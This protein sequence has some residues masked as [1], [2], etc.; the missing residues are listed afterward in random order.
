MQVST[1]EFI[2]QELSNW[3]SQAPLDKLQQDSFLE[4][5]Q[6]TS[7]R[8]MPIEVPLNDPVSVTHKVSISSV[9]I[10]SSV[11]D[12]LLKGFSKLGLGN[13][14]I[15]TAEQF[16]SWSSLIEEQIE[17]Q[18][19][20]MYIDQLNLLNK[21]KDYCSS[22]NEELK[23][24]LQFLDKLEN[25]CVSVT[26]KTNVLHDDCQQLVTDRT[27]LIEMAQDIENKLEYFT[28]YD[29]IQKY[30]SSPNLIVTGENFLATLKKIDSCM[31]FLTENSSFT[32][33]Q[34][35][36]EKYKACLLQALGMV[37]NYTISCLE[38]TTKS[39]LNQKTEQEEKD[40]PTTLVQEDAFTLY[41]GKFRAH[42]P[43][44]KTLTSELETRVTKSTEYQRYLSDIHYSYFS[45]REL[46]LSPSVT[47][48]MN[49]L[50]NQHQ[51]DH[52]ALVRSSCAFML[53]VC[54]DEHQLFKHFFNQPT[55]QLHDMLLNLC[56]SLYDMLR[57][58]IIQIYHLETLAE[59]CTIMIEMMDDQIHNNSHLTSFN[60]V[61]RQMLQDV[62]ERLV[63]R[64]NVY[65]KSEILNYQPSPGDLKYPDKL[66]MMEQ[67]AN[68]L[69]LEE[70]NKRNLNLGGDKFTDVKLGSDDESDDK[71]SRRDSVFTNS[72]ETYTSP[73]DVFGMWF[74]TVKRVLQCLSKLYRCIDKT[75]FQGLSQEALHACVQSLKNASNLIIS[76]GKTDPNKESVKLVDGQLFLIKHLLILREQ[77]TP[78]Q[79]EFVIRE[80]QLDFSSTV[81]A[82]IKFVSDPKTSVPNLLRTNS[83]NSILKLMYDGAPQ[84][85]EFYVDSKKDVD[86]QLK[87]ICENFIESQTK[88]LCSKI[89][90]FLH[91]ATSYIE[92]KKDSIVGD[93]KVVSDLNK[94][95]FAK[96]EL[97][98]DIV[99]ET[100][101]NLKTEVKKTVKSLSLYLANKETENILFKPIKVRVQKKFQT[102][103]EIIEEN[104]NEEE[105]QIIA[106]PSPDQVG[107][108]MTSTMKQ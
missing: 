97:L 11:E 85:K 69:K 13:E 100:Y 77:I 59:M 10:P 99:S 74:P 103:K 65:I 63:Y 22:I 7:Y 23:L 5:T 26:T 75:I 91:Q 39:I 73:A 20:E 2:T 33:S 42:A 19:D 9:P 80:T 32:E 38:N 34:S 17:K 12:I 29:S 37:K 8:P 66:L 93:V 51:K 44:I 41:Y 105:K 78:F 72:S 49:D 70:E 95:H 79:S 52:C 98:H 90:S 35:Y 46:L 84:V 108:L 24:S 61:V 89:I 107:L 68:N 15:E 16:Y 45:Q 21:Y 101:R 83:E 48:A 94:Q 87:E 57:P 104:F 31:D 102:L 25:E 27:K 81:D 82:T 14:K 88:T 92:L 43:K 64:A 62:Q 3:D 28:E 6:V 60:Q 67:I 47:S 50:L 4:L 106:A 53:H 36:L 30:L 96:P 86:K 56:G 40:T 76:S 71:L 54:D 58:L 18:G 55:Q 1:E